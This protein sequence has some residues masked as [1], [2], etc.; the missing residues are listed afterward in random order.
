MIEL[1]VVIAILGILALF[2]MP[3]FMGYST[4]AKNQVAKAN[5]RT[6]WT[7]AK[8]AETAS[9]YKDIKD[10]T[11]FIAEI[12]SKLGADFKDVAKGGDSGYSVTYDKDFHVT[13]VTYTTNGVACNYG[14]NGAADELKF[15]GD[16]AD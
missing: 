13:S 14:Y 2:L 7:A 12:N 10:D 9:E 1:I 6:V 3:Q 5:A 11:K 15:T 8:A 4:D 16:C